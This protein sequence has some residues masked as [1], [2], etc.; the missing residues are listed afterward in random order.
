MKTGHGNYF[1]TEFDPSEF[2]TARRMLGEALERTGFDVIRAYIFG[3]P[4]AEQGGFKPVG[5]PAFD[6][7]TMCYQ[8]VKAFLARS[9][10]SIEAATFMSADEIIAGS[11]FF[12]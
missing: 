11:R 1:I 12:G 10:A 8:V 4:V 9:G 6:G 3:D 2:E 7:Y 5:M